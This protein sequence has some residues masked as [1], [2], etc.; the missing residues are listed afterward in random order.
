MQKFYK[1]GKLSLLVKLSQFL[2]KYQAVKMYGGV[3]VLLHAFITSVLDEHAL[4]SLAVILLRKD[5][6][7]TQSQCF[8][9]KNLI[10]KINL[11]SK[12]LVGGG[13][14]LSDRL[15]TPH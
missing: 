15:R 1:L 14:L 3:E 7:K 11:C 2:I 13:V 12:R 8:E 5:P 10:P 6:P 4:H 9:E